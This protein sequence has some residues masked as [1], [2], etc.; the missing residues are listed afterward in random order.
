MQL[1]RL[2][3]FPIMTSLNPKEKGRGRE[4]R[5]K[6]KRG[7]LAHAIITCVEL[8]RKRSTPGEK[9]KKGGGGRGLGGRNPIPFVTPRMQKPEKKKGGGRKRDLP[10]AACV[11]SPHVFPSVV[12]VLMT[13]RREKEKRGKREGE[14]GRNE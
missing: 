4:E 10:H 2:K 3:A 9:E 11:I 7:T 8:F 13:K 14:R 5:G 12:A 1:P 6:R